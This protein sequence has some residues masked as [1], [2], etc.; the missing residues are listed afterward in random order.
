MN[1]VSLTVR[2]V[3]VSAILL[4]IALVLNL[5]TTFY[6]P[7]FGQNGMSVGIA[8]IFSMLPAFLFGP[9]Y[10]MIVAGLADLLGYLL[11]PAGA[12]LPLMTLIV[13]L[14]G[15]LRGLLWKALKNRSGR[16]LRIAVAA[17]S[18]LLLIVGLCNVLFL[19]ADGITADYYTAV[20]PAV[21][22]TDGMHMVS[23]LLITRTMN[24][25]DPAGSLATYITFVTAGV[26]GSAAL[27]LVLLLADWLL[28]KKF[29]LSKTAGQVPQLLIAMIVSGLIV[30]TL[31]TVLLRETL[32]AS[33]KVLPFTVVWIPRVIEEILSNTVK[34][35][36]VALLLG[37]A[38]RQRGL[39]ELT[40]AAPGKPA[41]KKG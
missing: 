17:F 8:G 29:K 11:K 22:N 16:V 41:A 34:A 3:A 20:Q 2:R 33:W 30:T 1:K 10:G 25:K 13:A 39:R 40:E 19:Q 6:I 5:T 21:A 32:Y 38:W 36:F 23:K 12:Y 14:G 4:S 24:A 9:V 31:N 26:I 28:T 15:L 37:V 18:V 27:G 7:L 35:Y